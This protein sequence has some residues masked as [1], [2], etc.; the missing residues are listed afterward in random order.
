MKIWQQNEKNNRTVINENMIGNSA[1][2]F[3]RFWELMLLKPSPKYDKR[4]AVIDAYI[5]AAII[6]AVVLPFLFSI[7]YRK[8]SIDV[9]FTFFLIGIFSFFRIATSKE[10]ICL[11]RTAYVFTF[12]FF[13][14]APLQQYSS[15]IVFWSDDDL[16][17]TYSSADYF[18][19]NMAIILFIVFFEIGKKKCLHIKKNSRLRGSA[20]G[21][22]TFTKNVSVKLMLMSTAAF[23]LLLITNN[24]FSTGSSY[25]Y[26]A[27]YSQLIN[28]LDYFPICSLLFYIMSNG[29]KIEKKYLLFIFVIAIECIVLFFPLW[30]KMARFM[31]FGTYLAIFSILFPHAKYKSLYFAAFIIGFCYFFSA[32]RYMTSL[33]NVFIPQIDFNNVD[34]DAYQ[35]I[36]LAMK[37]VNER[38]ISFGLNILSALMFLVPRGIWQGKMIGSGS[39]FAG[40]YGS[41]Q[42]NVSTPLVA[43]A[44]FAFGWLGLAVVGI[45]TGKIVRKIDSWIDATNYYKRG[46]FC[47][48]SGMT[49]YIMRGSL[50]ASLAFSFGLLLAMLFIGLICRVRIMPKSD[51]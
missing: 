48:F 21:N 44:F 11:T 50:L 14:M 4:E 26:T 27:V 46:T 25:A 49:I 35:M 1:N 47:I 8:M 15:G 16:N 29:K 37:Y 12:I 41:W 9:I 39:I 34:Y 38:G 6:I 43:E 30:G 33:K 40:Y 28:I 31:L 5:Y 7:D 24:V 17:V 18:S 23:L 19:A 2:V 20:M 13:F 36:M 3:N 42:L 45:I 10:N 51:T 32:T 22:I